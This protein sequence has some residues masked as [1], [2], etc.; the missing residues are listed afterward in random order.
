MAQPAS[1]GPWEQNWRT[2]THH[3]QAPP[4]P[5]PTFPNDKNKSPLQ[6]NQYI[7][8]A[9]CWLLLPPA[10]LQVCWWQGPV[11]LARKNFVCV[12]SSKNIQH[13]N[14]SSTQ[15]KNEH[16]PGQPKRNSRIDA[17]AQNTVN[18]DSETENIWTWILH[19]VG[20]CCPLHFC[21]F[22]GGLG[23]CRVFHASA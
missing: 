23:P 6:L 7:T 14:H 10:Y 4:P 15:S 11:Q 12:T 17:T 13:K 2:H 5:V 18:N 19:F 3:T 21:R 1:H 16:R 8:A 20:P 22:V 9:F